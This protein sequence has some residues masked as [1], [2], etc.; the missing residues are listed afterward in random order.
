MI[1]I[2]MTYSK[3]TP[4]SI[5]LG[6]TSDN[7]FYERGGWYYSI[8]KGIEGVEVPEALKFDNIEDA[9]RF[10]QWEGI[11]ELSEKVGGQLDLV[12]CDNTDFK[13]G[14]V[15][16]I[17]YHLESTDPEAIAEIVHSF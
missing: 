10:L 14:E 7:G 16:Q 1:T 15:T 3:Y 4:E 12:G 13:T 11:Q 6:C 5:E 2:N 8:A 9:V 17:T